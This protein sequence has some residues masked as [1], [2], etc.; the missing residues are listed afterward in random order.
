MTTHQVIDKIFKD[1]AVKFDL[2]EF[3]ASGKPIHEMIN[4]YS[5]KWNW[6]SNRKKIYFL[7]PLA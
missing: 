2:S 1:L 3:E 7:K 5:K 4:I 6:K